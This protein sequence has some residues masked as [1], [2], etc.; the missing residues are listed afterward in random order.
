MSGISHLL[1]CIVEVTSESEKNKVQYS[2]S[3]NFFFV[4]FSRYRILYYADGRI[5]PA[6]GTQ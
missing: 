4:L 6:I 5:S 2:I 3:K 1:P